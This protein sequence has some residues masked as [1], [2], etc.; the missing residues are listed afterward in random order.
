MLTELETRFAELAMKIMLIYTDKFFPIITAASGAKFV[1]GLFKITEAKTVHNRLEG[2]DP[3]PSNIH[4][5]II[6]E[7]VIFT[8]LKE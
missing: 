2:A 4:L 6:L 3:S 8:A 1:S 7:L 5:S